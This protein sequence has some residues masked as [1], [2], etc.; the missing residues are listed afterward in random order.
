MKKNDYDETIKIADEILEYY[1]K[2]P[3][4]ANATSPHHESHY[5]RFDGEG[6][7]VVSNSSAFWLPDIRITE[8]VKNVTY[9]VDGSYEGSELLH[10]K[11]ERI[12][13]HDI[14]ENPEET[15]NE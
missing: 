7:L 14:N 2:N 4:E 3:D 8:Q 5:T 15:D 6:R 10:E 9:V 12:L 11:F 1:F 13:I